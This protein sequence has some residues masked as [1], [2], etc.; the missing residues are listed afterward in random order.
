[1]VELVDHAHIVDFA[2]GMQVRDGATAGIMTV[3]NIRPR[4]AVGCDASEPS[5]RR[6]SRS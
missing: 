4:V 1:V 3:Y 6:G 2:G 5:Q